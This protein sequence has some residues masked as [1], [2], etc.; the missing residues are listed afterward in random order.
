MTELI[1][2]GIVPNGVAANPIKGLGGDLPPSKPIGGHD[3]INS[4]SG[5]PSPRRFNAWGG[6][7]L[8]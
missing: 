7:V 3:T 4:V 5:Y 2:T 1:D 8:P 6:V